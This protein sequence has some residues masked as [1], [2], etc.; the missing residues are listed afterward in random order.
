MARICT[1]IATSH[2]PFLFR[3]LPWWN[4]VRDARSRAP[5][6]PVDSDAENANKLTR[7]QAAQAQLK[8]VFQAAKPDI[9]VVFGDDQEEQFTLHTMPP[10]ALFVG[11]SFAGYRAVA[12]EGT[13]G[14]PGG[15][16]LLPKTAEH[17]V[18][19]NAHPQLA[20]FLLQHWMRS[21]FDPAYM[22]ALPNAE[23]GM[24][25][26]FMRPM[27]TLTSGRFDVPVVPVLINCFYAPQPSAKRC[28]AAA[29]AIRA[30]IEGW[31]QDLNVAVIGSGGL[32]HTPGAKDAYID[33][34][35]DRAILERL[36]AGDADGMARYFDDWQPPAEHA[37]L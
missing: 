7:T 4:S 11:E 25:H 26:A 36:A 30:A 32:W 34:T 20:R 33:E 29:R 27:S 22:T 8:A 12:Y 13:P 23:H 37:Q 19:V 6:A 21:G 18:Q 10:L 2:S 15:R 3:P 24:G 35:F 9:A 5:G 31:P 17:W 1:V 28:V 16:K 14:V